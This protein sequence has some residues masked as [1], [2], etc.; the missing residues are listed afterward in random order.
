MEGLCYRDLSPL[1]VRDKELSYNRRQQ[2][3]TQHECQA[4]SSQH[5]GANLATGHWQRG[6]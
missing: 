3:G 5:S 2:C 4:G 1:L 6:H